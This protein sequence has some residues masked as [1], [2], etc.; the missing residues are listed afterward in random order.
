MDFFN[1]AKE[2]LQS[3]GKEM[4]QKASDVSGVARLNM[5][6]REDEKGIAKAINDI[7]VMM[8]EQHPDETQK[9]CPELYN[10]LINL[11]KQL[12][13]DKNE[14]AV[15]KGLMICP[16]CGA[17]QDPNVMCCTACGMNVNEARRML[18]QSHGPAFCGKCGA[19]IM[20]EAKFCMK[21]GTPV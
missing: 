13:S 15:C 2:S 19:E 5:K 9:L 16:N 18:A 20:G 7:G 8:V 17:E 6:V 3:A 11:Q 10:V 14:L 1:K 21:C 4:A 12:I